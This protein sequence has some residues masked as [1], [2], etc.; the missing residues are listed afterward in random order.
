MDS[1]E[2]TRFRSKIYVR[3]PDV[4]MEQS[5][6]HQYNE[7]CWRG[8]NSDFGDG[9]W[10]WTDSLVTQGYGRMALTDGRLQYAHRLAY[11]HFVLLPLGEK[12]KGGIHI[13]HRERC[14]NRACVNPRHLVVF[15][16]PV[17]K[18]AQGG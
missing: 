14:R 4:T 16:M 10:V 1:S 9:C 13:E 8:D 2:L 12:L 5:L 15:K 17:F 18:T 3:N 11:E 7:G 6:G